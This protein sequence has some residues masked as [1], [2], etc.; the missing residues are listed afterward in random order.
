MRWCRGL[1]RV[2]SGL[3]IIM[4]AS[5]C[6]EEQIAPNP[7]AELADI[8][9]SVAVM[10][11]RADSAA[12]LQAAARTLAVALGEADIRDQLKAAL[13][14]SS[15]REG[16]LHL[17]RF[18]HNRGSNFG[19]G[20]GMAT[21]LGDGGW[22]EVIERLPDLEM[23]LPVPEHRESWAGTDDLLVVGFIETDEEI[24]GRG[25]YTAF[26]TRG[27]PLLIP[28]GEV[29]TRPVLA[30][31]PVETAF[32]STGEEPSGETSATLA[33]TD[34]GLSYIIVP[35]PEP[36]PAGYCGSE[37]TTD[38]YVYICKI[39]IPNIGQYEEFLRGAPEVA[40]L[41]RA[42]T[43]NSS[44]VPSSWTDIG[45]NNEDKS[46]ASRLNMDND[47]WGGR[48]RVAPRTTIQAEQA[49]GKR[50]FIMVWEDDNGSKCD[51]QPEAVA[52]AQNVS[53]AT[54][55]RF[56]QIFT[57]AGIAQI[58]DGNPAGWILAS[59]SGA[60]AEVFGM[61]ANSGDDL[62]GSV[63]LPAGGDPMKSVK[64]IRINETTVRG[65]ITFLL[66]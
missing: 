63:A 38:A 61:F 64:D 59:V 30:I 34:G 23:Y 43:V 31:Y 12:V 6:A 47:T 8:Q 57:L 56:A 24:R 16:K 22:S 5:A 40:V 41:T 49:A 62:I 1:R 50:T 11:T 3:L 25:G 58:L 2:G 7:R 54:M 46:D 4:G 19:R 26:T 48:A 55:M 17:Q 32:G 29:P 9:A 44:N 65:N 27:E 33:A 28:H 45:C 18:L 42:V 51:F 53:W 36:A 35:P 13:G 60:I 10:Q 20:V 15:V 14:R 21:G 66:D 37:T 39:N 52:A